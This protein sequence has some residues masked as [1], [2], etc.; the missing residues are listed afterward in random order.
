M[1]GYR[2]PS[3]RPWVPTEKGNEGSNPLYL[4]EC[5]P[6]IHRPHCL[7][8]H[9][10]G[11]TIIFAGT[12]GYGYTGGGLFIWDRERNTGTLLGHTD[13]LQEQSTMGLVALPDGNIMGG[14]TTA[15][16]TGGE[17]KATE[18]ELYLLDIGGRRLV[19][20]EAVFPGAQEYTDLCPGP[21]GL[22][23]GFADRKHFFVF[24]PVGKKVVHEQET[25]SLFG[26]TSTQQGPRVF[27]YD[28]DQGIYILFVKGI[29]RLDPETF[30]I[31]I[32]AESPV[33]IGPGGDI[34]KGRIYFGSGSHLYSWQL[35]G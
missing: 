31:K 16:G 32:L 18:A 8:A 35:P 17:K 4:T 5:T 10:D 13:L 15:P 24:D 11:R 28:L 34:L 33:P 30:E 29:A 6:T 14:T 22:V 2:R 3:S 20:H 12:P 26:P 21:R 25:E 27:H 23:L 7:L 9:P 1:P 19:W